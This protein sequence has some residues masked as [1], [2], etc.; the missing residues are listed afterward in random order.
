MIYPAD[1]E[2]KIGFDRIRAMLL[3]RCIST[4]GQGQ[5]GSMGML[6]GK[7]KIEQF[8][9]QTEEFR[10]ILLQ[11]LPFPQSNYFDPTETFRRIKPLDTFLE[12][13]EMLDLKN[14]YE[15]ILG[16]VSFLCQ[17][18][19]KESLKFKALAV[20]ISQLET[21]AKLPAYIA[22]IIDDRAQVRNSA[23]MALLE[24]RERC[25]KLEIDA[26]RKIAQLL[27]YAKSQGL[28][29]GDVE[30]ALRNGRQV[31]PIAAGH[32]RKIRG[33]VHDQSAS[34]QTVYIEPEEV[35]E[36]NNEIRELEMAERREI[37]RIL[38]AFTDRLRPLLPQ[39]NH[40]YRMLAIVDSIRAKALLAIE[41]QAQKPRIN[42]NPG[43]QWIKAI[44]PLLYLSHKTQNK[45]V[46]PLDIILTH[47][48]R[49]LVIS[50]P[51][52]GGK[53][54]CLKTCGLLQYMLQC[55]MLVPMA[56]YSEAGI[57]EQI[58]I[59]I[60]DQQSLEND[61]STYSSHLHNMKYFMERCN[62]KTL[63]LIDEFGAGTEPRLGGAIAEA[64]LEKL[65]QKG[66]FGVITT[67]YANLKLMAANHKGIANGSMLFDT[68]SM[69]P[70]F[71]LKTGNPG[72]SFAFEI[73][74]SIGLSENILQQAGVYAGMQELDFDRQLHDLDLRKAELEDKEK[75][76]R[77]AD[78]F[79]S[80]MIDRYE[81]LSGDLE[82]RKS[83]IM[84]QTRLEAKKLL[85]ETNRMIENT[86]RK[87]KEAQAG[88]E[89][90]RQA[91]QEMDQFIASQEE[92]FLK[93]KPLTP[94]EKKPVPVAER[95]NTPFK[96]GDAVR[97][98]DQQTIGEVIEVSGGNVII[99]FG[100]IKFKTKITALEKIKKSSLPP[101]EDRKVRIKL[102][103]D[104]NEKAAEFNPQIDL[105]GE[106]VVDALEKLRRYIDDALLL[107]AKQIKILHGKGDGIL[108]EATRVMLQG[109]PEV[110]GYRDEHPDRG[111]AGATIVDFK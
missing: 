5:I 84:A 83:E 7:E 109:I 6:K 91:R 20:L 44:H 13:E 60:G 75:Q 43:M 55:G 4:L 111:G 41:M 86:I 72:S 82:A 8:L 62:E 11:G 21:E 9:D 22:H 47:E 52:A 51:N 54:V 63:F 34:G 46:E 92:K 48:N 105:K 69:R 100:S 39:L 49:I 78:Q 110:S 73:A 17:H 98:K 76:L 61:L 24:I 94:S 65:N 12:A 50:G 67:H 37:I 18:D 97:V 57:F 59:D 74:R 68:R 2:I 26:N 15:T 30:L 28:V 10:Q 19:G 36:I 93:P 29:A 38:K 79:L 66:A 23:S 106:R 33:I 96:V 102:A 104:I 45:H 16:I 89:E 58:F 40:C 31:I 1:F 32:K 95:D 25:H 77:S 87:I 70:L 53:S 27:Q 64:I 99:S 85:A 88:K 101:A 90:T 107:G 108:R 42:A 80:E 71:R 103:F 81:K 14:S 56:D 3:N 35:F